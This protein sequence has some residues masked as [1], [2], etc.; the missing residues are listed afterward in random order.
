MKRILF[1]AITAMALIEEAC[2]VAKLTPND[3]QAKGFSTVL[4][5]PEPSRSDCHAWGNIQVCL[6]REDG[7]V[8]GKIDLPDGLPGWVVRVAMPD[9]VIDGTLAW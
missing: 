5:M 2:V 9:E 1:M 8:H 3:M 7:Q 6:R 4:E